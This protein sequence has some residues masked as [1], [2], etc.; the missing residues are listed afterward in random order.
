M[1][2][3][4]EC[5]YNSLYGHISYAVINVEPNKKPF[6]ENGIEN[7]QLFFEVFTHLHQRIGQITAFV[8]FPKE[9]H[10]EFEKESHN[11]H[12]LYLQMKCLLTTLYC[13]QRE[14]IGSTLH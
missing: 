6:S 7:L 14:T 1:L 2:T 11:E 12:N 13:K 10:K 5:A 3:F 8:L 4:L 9:W